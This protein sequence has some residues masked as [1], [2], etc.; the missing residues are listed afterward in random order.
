[1]H[2]AVSA[3]LALS[4]CTSSPAAAGD[5]AP[6]ACVPTTC[7]TIG[8]TCGT[9][10]DGCGATL[11]CGTCAEPDVCNAELTCETPCTP[12]GALLFDLGGTLVLEQ[13]DG[14]FADAPGA[15]ALLDALRNQGLPLGVVTNVPA[16]WTEADVRALLVNPSIL[17][18][19]D[20]VLLSS[21]ATA[22]AKPDPD[23]FLEAL[24]LLPAPPPVEQVAYVSEAIAEIANAEPPTRGARAAGLIGVHVSAEA[25]DPLADHTVAPDALAGMAGA[26]WVEC[27]EAE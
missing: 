21:E 11:S 2:L 4:A 20:V 12:L 6:A 14:T 23:I 25:P 18:G 27:I 5:E 1:M 26:P 17:D 24:A 13:E 19:F 15:V 16:G 8:A 7:E 10:D 9:V 22:H 3:L